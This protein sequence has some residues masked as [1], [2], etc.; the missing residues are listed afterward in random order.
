[1]EVKWKWSELKKRRE[2]GRT[3]RRNS[4]HR[5]PE[6]QSVGIEGMNMGPEVGVEGW[7]GSVMLAS[8]YPS[9][10]QTNSAVNGKP[11]Y[12]SIEEVT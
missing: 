5:G 4:M 9:E 8:L 12:L 11:L 7:V 1:M 10:I 6:S 2:L 3:S